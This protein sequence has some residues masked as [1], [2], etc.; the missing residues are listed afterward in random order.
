MLVHPRARKYLSGIHVAAHNV[1]IF[2]AKIQKNNEMGKCF[3]GNI[4][5]YKAEVYMVQSA[6]KR[7]LCHAL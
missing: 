3:G 6:R 5:N 1:R 4:A 2:A 7:A